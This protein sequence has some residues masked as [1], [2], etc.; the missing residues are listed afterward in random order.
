MKRILVI[1]F[2]ITL[3]LFLIAN[4]MAAFHAYKFT[5]FEKNAIL[6][7]KNPED[8][9]FTQKLNALFF[10][11]SLPRPESDLLPGDEFRN[12]VVNNEIACW[13]IK[14]PND[15]GTVIL[16]HGYGSNKASVLG[17]AQE[18]NR[19]GYTAFLVDFKGSG[20]SVGNETTI[21]FKESQD[22]KACYDYIKSQNPKSIILCGTSMGAVA[23]MKCV[24]ET[25]IHPNYLVLECPFGSMK[26]T[27]SN[28]FT[29]MGLPSFPLCDLLV[30]YGGIMNGFWAFDHN[31]IDY[32]KN[33]HIPTLLLCGGKD[34]RV[35]QKEID[36]I[37]LNLKSTKEKIIYPL[38]K[39]ES[40]LN[41]YRE[42][43]REDVECFLENP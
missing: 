36:D 24:S 34:E 43:W 28:R 29:A 27:V 17:K 21:G 39:H 22:V 11:V 14:V 12:V 3:F 42:D 25:N 32:A 40:Y 18:F 7:G 1:F 37:F 4:F 2:R 13:E 5:H 26:Q 38:A 10:G 31:P 15:K 8:L 23:I 20:G 19:M 16:F 41:E 30:F 9:N 35:T 33:I 6:I